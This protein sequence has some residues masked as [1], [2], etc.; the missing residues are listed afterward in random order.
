MFKYVKL[1]FLQISDR[2]CPDNKLLSSH[3]LKTLDVHDDL[4][5]L[6][7]RPLL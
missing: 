1:V 4:I 5:V 6:T 3:V 7:I 2:Y